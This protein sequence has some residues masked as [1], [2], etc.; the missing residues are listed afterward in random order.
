MIAV[1]NILNTANQIITTGSLT[2]LE[3]VQLSTIPNFLEKSVG[4][5]DDLDSLPSD[6][7]NN[8]GR[9]V[10]VTDLNYYYFSDGSKWTDD[11]NTDYFL[12]RVLYAW[13]DGNGYKTISSSADV[14][15]PV[16]LTSEITTWKKISGGSSFT[17]GITTANVAYAW[18]QNSYGQLGVGDVTQR[19]TPTLIAGGITNWK[20]ISASP[21]DTGDYALGLTWAGILYSWGRNDVGQLGSNSTVSRSSPVTVIGGITTWNQISAGSYYNF[22]VT[23]SGIAYGWG[24]NSNGQLGDNTVTSQSSPVTVVGGITNWSKVLTSGQ[25]TNFSIGI[26]STG[27]VYTWGANDQGQLGN[28]TTISRSSPGTILG[29]IATWSDIGV[30]NSSG[31]AITVIEKGI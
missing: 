16:A 9:L 21:S 4:S 22:G 2:D 15:S 23:S 24:F 8:K 25:A 3:I 29:N 26:T 18:G 13:G 5:F 17:T 27:A 31:F 28:G 20:E 11:Y 30:A 14:S 12:R 1:E 7:A 6:T 19:A 10:Y